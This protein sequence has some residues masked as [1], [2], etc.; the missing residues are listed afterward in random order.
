MA[1]EIRS[2]LTFEAQQ[3]INTLNRM[4]QEL[5][6]YNAAVTSAAQGTS[7][8]N[9]AGT[10]FDR[11]AAATAAS[12][13]K[14]G[15]AASAAGKQLGGIS[16]A[17]N[18]AAIQRFNALFETSRDRIKRASDDVVKSFRTQEQGAKSLGDTL[19]KSGKQ[20]AAAGKQVL[21]SWQ[22][23]TRIFAIQVIHQAISRITQA[24]SGG[25]RDAL[26]Y[27]KALSEIQ[28]IGGD[29]DL[30]LG[31]L[32]DRV[33]QVSDAFGQPIDVVAEGVYQTLSNQVGEASEAF[34]FLESANKLATAAVASTDDSVNLLSSAIN[35]FNLNVEDSDDIAAKFFKTIE[36]GRVR[37]GELANTFGRVGVL[38]SQLG[39]SFDETLASIASLTGSG[40]RIN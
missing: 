17:Q 33:R 4:E 2:E 7:A 22:S 1:E 23:V 36:L 14:L 15:T 32:D 24:F 9:A 29:L 5:A 19:E 3:A 8:F 30:T 37:A 38:S 21:L 16:S 20:G 34:G 27:Q 31:E 12:L 25:I 40:L 28:T 11:T 26:E 10:R 13:N 6:Q 18:Q 35:S 39:V